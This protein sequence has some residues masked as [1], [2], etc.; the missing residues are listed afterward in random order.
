[1]IITTISNNKIKVLG[2]TIQLLLQIGKFLSTQIY[3][4]CQNL[5]LVLLRAALKGNKMM[6]S[7]NEIISL[8]LLI[9]DSIINIKELLNFKITSHN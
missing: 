9:I 7:H 2:L 4:P 1:M 8:N 5:L 3:M 6:E